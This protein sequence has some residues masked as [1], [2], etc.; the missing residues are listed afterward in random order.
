MAS[1]SILFLMRVILTEQ[2]VSYLGKQR[3]TVKKLELYGSFEDTEW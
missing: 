2:S 1:S 3:T